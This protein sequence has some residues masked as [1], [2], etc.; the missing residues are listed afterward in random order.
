M[1]TRHTAASCERSRHDRAWSLSSIQLCHV[2][3]DHNSRRCRHRSSI[4]RRMNQTSANQC[5]IA[6]VRHSIFNC[7]SQKYV[8]RNRHHKVNR[9]YEF[10]PFNSMISHASFDTARLPVERRTR[11]QNEKSTRKVDWLLGC[12]TAHQHTTVISAVVRMIFFKIKN[13]LQRHAG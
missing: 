12:L 5:Y 7:R 9:F 6:P 1:F 13:Q 8:P 10:I 11:K 2:W 4:R 3:H